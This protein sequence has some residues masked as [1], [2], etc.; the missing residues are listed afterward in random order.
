MKAKD[1]FQKYDDGIIAE[2]KDPKIRTDGAIAK[3]FMEFFEEVNT[4][5]EQRHIKFDRGI[6][7]AV[8]EQNKKWNAVVNMFIK[9]YG[10][11]PI[12][13]DGFKTAFYLTINKGT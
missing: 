2:A 12:E 13:K 3:M 8:D 5:I 4:I 6:I 11:T 10:V 7:P 1:Y 9:K